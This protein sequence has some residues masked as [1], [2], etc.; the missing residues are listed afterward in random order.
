M[1]ALTMKRFVVMSTLLC[2]FLACNN[3]SEEKE[4]RIVE[5][6]NFDWQF[7]IGDFPEAIDSTFNAENWRTLNLPHDWSI[8]G[9]FSEDHPAK[10]EGG[11]LPT[12][13]A[14]YRKTFKLPADYKNKSISIEFDGIYRKSEV[15]INGQYLG[16]RPNGY[17]S[18]AYDLS[19][20]LNYGETENII[21]VKVDNSEQP[22]SRWYSG[23]GIAVFAADFI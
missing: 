21:A 15:W 13:V 4:V 16:I 5:D 17:I 12:G 8:E 19:E 23:S 7:S 18:F 22:N 11:A 1:K 3:S 2:L 20:H 10:P 6:F 14:W 9:E